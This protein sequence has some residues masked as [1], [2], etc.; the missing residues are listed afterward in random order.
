VA[1]A[2]V[3]CGVLVLLWVIEGAPSPGDG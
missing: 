3:V 2:C 1:D